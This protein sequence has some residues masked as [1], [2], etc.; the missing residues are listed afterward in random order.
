MNRKIMVFVVGLLA[1]GALEFGLLGASAS[2]IVGGSGNTLP[3]IVDRGNVPVATSTPETFIPTS[4]PTPVSATDPGCAIS[5]PDRRRALAR[6][7]HRAEPAAAFGHS[8]RRFQHLAASRHPA[9]SIRQ[10]G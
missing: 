5:P 9:Q 2:G 3:P 10:R 1:L 6:G 8:V 7:E 4:T